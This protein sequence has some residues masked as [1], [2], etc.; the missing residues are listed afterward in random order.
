MLKHKESLERKVTDSMLFN[1]QCEHS[2]LDTIRRNLFIIMVNMG[3]LEL[4]LVRILGFY[5]QVFILKFPAFASYDEARRY[6]QE[7]VGNLIEVQQVCQTVS[8]PVVLGVLT[9]EVRTKLSDC[10]AIGQR[11]WWRRCQLFKKDLYTDP[12]CI[13]TLNL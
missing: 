7:M 13:W 2:A 6:M 8:E 4:L 3:D 5:R 10:V 9:D 11:N 12:S 1:L